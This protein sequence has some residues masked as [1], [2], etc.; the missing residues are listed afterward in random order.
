MPNLPAPT[1][2][3]RDANHAQ[4]L[5]DTDAPIEA[6]SSDLNESIALASRPANAL[7]L[8]DIIYTVALRWRLLLA[9]FLVPCLL[10]LAAAMISQPKFIGSAVMMVLVN[11]E[12]STAPDLSGFG[13]S[14][15]AVEMLKVV[16]A[17]MEIL[18]SPATI[19]TALQQVGINTI[20]P[21][22][23]TPTALDSPDATEFAMQTAVEKFAL[24]L[25]TDTDTNTN[26]IR[27]DFGSNSR[28]ISLAAVQALLDAYMKR[29]NEVLSAD[30]SRILADELQRYQAQLTTTETELQ[31]V[32]SRYGVL[33]ITQ[34]QQIATTR[35]DSVS[36]RLDGVREQLA[37]NQALLI[38]AQNLLAS[39]PTQVLAERSTASSAPNDDARNMLNRLLNDRERMAAAY[40]PGY[41]P[42]RDLDE[43]IAAARRTLQAS[44]QQSFATVRQA[45]NPQFDGL[46]Q[47]VIDL[48]LEHSALVEQQRELEQQRADAL[49]REA[50]LRAAEVQLRD[51]Q[52]RRDALETV[53]KQLTTHEAG[54]RISEEAGGLRNTNV[55]VVQPPVAPLKGKSQRR[56]IVMGGTAGGG[57]AAA[58]L[59]LILALTRRVFATPEE[60]QRTLGLHNLGAFAAF[61]T[62]RHRKADQDR[63]DEAKIGDLAA[64]LLDL[65][66]DG[67]S[68]GVIQLVGTDS[69]DERR[70][71]G[72]A[73]FAELNLRLDGAA[74]L[75]DL[76]PQQAIIAGN[77]PQSQAQERAR[78]LIDAALPLDVVRTELSQLRQSARAVV[79]LG[80]DHA[81][82]YGSRR[83]SGLVDGN[84]LVVRGELSQTGMV[85]ANLENT[86]H[87][88]GMVLG[89]IYTGARPVLPRWV[90]RWL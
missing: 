34:E 64:M 14:V 26:L 90:A 43:A 18:Q 71:I 11:R 38:K 20:Y 49:V 41:P 13:P 27:V 29:R 69:R 51:L 83:L 30:G 50:E 5:H 72:R 9:T 28:A 6:M 47:R 62:L 53:V 55:K 73:L 40:A 2:E 77:V 3:L 36:Q 81:D 66:H 35:R 15:I 37:T 57:M 1:A 70:S 65:S 46:S 80:P 88:G 48:S 4:S 87:A 10:S 21:S 39:A 74:M 61:D 54:N 32:R 42:L 22:L 79:L 17:E 60:V 78:R 12:S 84:I 19:R 25:H 33:D 75:I 85:R 31:Q 23:P 63:A 44:A 89:F 52:G 68:A 56:L 82:G 45:R 76:E 59:C 24:D 86:L 7:R 16:R 8:I 58:A 67:G